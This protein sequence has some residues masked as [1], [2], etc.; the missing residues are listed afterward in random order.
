M[1]CGSVIDDFLQGA[2]TILWPQDAKPRAR[3]WMTEYLITQYLILIDAIF[4]RHTET[5][6]H[7]A[8]KT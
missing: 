3:P 6:Q 8:D 2:R 7:N 1:S 5:E 4:D